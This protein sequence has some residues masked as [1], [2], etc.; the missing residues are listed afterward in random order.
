MRSFISI[1]HNTG[2]KAQQ[3]KTLHARRQCCG[4][5]VIEPIYDIKSW[6]RG[7]LTQT[8]FFLLGGRHRAPKNPKPFTPTTAAPNELPLQPCS[9]DTR[10]HALSPSKG[11]R[12]QAPLA[13]HHAERHLLR[14]P[15][16]HPDLPQVQI[17]EGLQQHH[18]VAGRENRLKAHVQCLRR[19]YRD[20]HLQR[21]TRGDGSGGGERRGAKLVEGFREWK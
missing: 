10:P 21:R 5:S 15:A 7:H 3:R 12:V 6:S 17:K 20:S 11:F 19:S 16:R 13:V 1:A 14:H 18:L 2:T 4:A 8:L 9:H